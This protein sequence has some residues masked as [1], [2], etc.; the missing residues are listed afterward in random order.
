MDIKIRPATHQDAEGI[1]MILADTGWYSN[2]N[3][4]PIQTRQLIEKHLWQLN[5]A[6]NQS[7]LVVETE[8]K[9]VGYIT[10]YW[11]S[12]YTSYPSELFECYVSELY[13]HPNYQ[14]SGLGTA[15]LEHAKDLAR[16][17]GCPKLT[18]ISAKHRGSYDFYKKLGWAERTDLV[19]FD[20]R[21]N[22]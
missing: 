13:I 20:W 12:Y 19:E 6:S 2:I 14:N 5:D 16:S 10:L 11:M 7:V 22:S 21:L 9:I 1:I 15:L 8:Q 17:K 18:L 3:A 4:N